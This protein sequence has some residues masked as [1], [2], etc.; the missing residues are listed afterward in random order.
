MCRPNQLTQFYYISRTLFL[1]KTIKHR[2]DT[3][4][5][6]APISGCFPPEIWARI[7]QSC[8]VACDEIP[9]GAR[10]ITSGAK[11]STGNV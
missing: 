5:L 3:D 2:I 7:L 6:N 10:E 11:S 4:Q 9:C 8:G 1:L